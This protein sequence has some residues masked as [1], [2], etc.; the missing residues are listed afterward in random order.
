M[1]KAIKWAAFLTVVLLLPAQ[2]FALEA[3]PWTNEATYEEKVAAKFAYG[4]KNLA[5]GWT[6]LITEPVEYKKEGK[7]PLTGFGVGLYNAIGQTVGGALHVVTFPVPV[8]VRLPE[9]GTDFVK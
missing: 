4:L 7:C 3:S 6:E 8:D 5:F 9:N 2:A 1:T